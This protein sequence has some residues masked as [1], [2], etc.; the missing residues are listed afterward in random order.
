MDIR[1]LCA[2]GPRWSVENDQTQ[3]LIPNMKLTLQHQNV[4]S[5][6]TLDS[7]VEEQIITLQPALQIDDAVISLSHDN[8]ASPA[9]HVGAHLIT[10][11]PDVFAEGCDHT[12]QAA[13]IKLMESLRGKISDRST[14]REKR[15]RNQ[16]SPRSSHG[17]VTPHSA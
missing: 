2:E 11:G 6:D 14:N 16:G 17:R 9:F 8:D 3:D 4:R 7:W 13:F 15:Q 10:P 12:L 1:P 5:T